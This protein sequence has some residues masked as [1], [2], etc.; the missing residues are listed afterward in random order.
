M[1]SLPRYFAEPNLPSLSLPKQQDVWGPVFGEMAGLAHAMIQKQKPIDAARYSSEYDIAM[2]D[3]KNQVEAEGDPNTMRDRFM[4]KEREKRTEILGQVAD[5]ETQR[6]ITE[7]ADRRYGP[8]V[9]NV[10]ERQ[11][12]SSHATQMGQI[13]VVGKTLAKQAGE[14]DDPTVRASAIGTYNAMVASASSTTMIANRMVPASISVKDAEK[15]KADFLL[16][17]LRDRSKFLGEVNPYKLREEY[18]NGV[19]KSLPLD[20]QAGV[21]ERVRVGQ[22]NTEAVTDKNAANISDVLMREAEARANFGLLSDRFLNS[23]M[24]NLEPYMK[25]SEGRRLKAI[26]D[27]PPTGDGSDNVRSIM[28]EYYL[29]GG[30]TQPA[31]DKA[32]RA[33]NALQGRMERPNPLIM[34]AAN[35]LQSDQTAVENL[36]AA[37]MNRQINA[38]HDEYDAVSPPTLPFLRNIIPNKRQQDLGKIDST[39]RKGGDPAP[40]IKQ[41][42]GENKA[43]SEATPQKYKDVMEYGP[44]R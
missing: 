37:R 20:E 1:G 25:P 32:R 44:Q 38:A 31:I 17:V 15:M 9:I 26:N 2:E 27:N 13:A 33:L 12:K 22:S 30:R 41:K 42:A 21:L 28:S 16:D 4:E 18:R 23:V 19:Y 40:L 11:I 10:T 43:K 34:K 6:A 5:A 39:I 8:N 24:S 3:I 29:S 36:D 35:E 7:H 14:T